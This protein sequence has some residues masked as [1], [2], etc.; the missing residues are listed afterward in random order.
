MYGGCFDIKLEGSSLESEMDAAGARMYMLTR[1]LAMGADTVA[2]VVALD[3]D[4]RS[5]VIC[6]WVFGE[7]S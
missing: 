7:E 2:V 5:G 3:S 6:Y 4:L 1:L